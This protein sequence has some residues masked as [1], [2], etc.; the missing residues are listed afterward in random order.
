MIAVVL[1][2]VMT[3]APALASVCAMSCAAGEAMATSASVDKHDF[4]MV[5]DHCRQMAVEASKNKSGHHAQAAAHKSCAMMGCNFS[6]A[7]PLTALAQVSILDFV[8]APVWDF[9]PPAFSAELSPPI[10][11]PA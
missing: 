6:Q 8:S 9:N 7:A 2:L 3:S 1:I 11:P 4:A 10:K 5:S